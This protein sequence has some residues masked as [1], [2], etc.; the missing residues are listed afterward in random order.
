M[1]IGWC[2]NDSS[3]VMA[4]MDPNAF[5]F[6]DADDRLAAGSWGP[7]HFLWDVVQ[8]I[9]ALDEASSKL[10]T[11][12]TEPFVDSKFYDPTGGAS[13]TFARDRLGAAHVFRMPCMPQ[14]FCDRAFVGAGSAS[15]MATQTDEG[16]WLIDASGIQQRTPYGPGRGL[17][18]TSQRTCFPRSPR[19]RA[20]NAGSKPAAQSAFQRRAL[21]HARARAQDLGQLAK[22]LISGQNVAVAQVPTRLPIDGHRGLEGEPVVVVLD[23]AGAWVAPVAVEKSATC[24]LGICRL[25]AGAGQTL[26]GP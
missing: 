1:A 20:A 2:L 10:F 16:L 18:H 25:P 19:Q 3:G 24:R 15:G 11:D 4:A 7:R 22:A 12:T 13:V 23:P 8:D 9:D 21:R 17:T 6:A 26:P 14:V 5:T